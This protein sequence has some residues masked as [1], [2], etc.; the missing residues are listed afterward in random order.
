M[1]QKEFEEKVKEM[2]IDTVTPLL[3]QHGKKL[4]DVKGEIDGKIKE[5]SSQVTKPAVEVGAEAVEKDPKGGF[6]SLS[7]FA[8]HVAMAEKT[9]NRHLSKELTAWEQYCK[10]ADSTTLEEGELQYGGY[11]I[12]PEFRNELWLAVEQMNEILPRCTQIPMARTMVKIPFVNGFDESG[13]LVYGGIRW[14]W[15]DELGTKDPSRPKLGRI[16]LE[17][18]KI[19]GLAYSSDELL[20][21]SP[22]SIENVLR[23]GFTDGLNFELTNVLI[24]GTGAG[25]PLGILNAPCLVTVT[26]ETGQSAGTIVFEN[27]V[28]M[29]SR[30]H[31]PANAVWVANSNT[32]PQL[33][34]MSLSV[35]TGGVPVFMPANGAAGVPYNTLMGRP[36]IFS[37]HC[38]TLGTVGDI[39]FADWS[40]YLVGMKSGQGATGKFDTS[41]H[42][43]FDADQT[44]FRFVFRIDGQP[45][46]PSALTPPQATSDTLSPFVALASRT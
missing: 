12:P 31:N 16:T 24:R 39:V 22:I 26:K 15:T 19:A 34:T 5:I 18:R 6:K 11:L 35:G 2:L 7:H 10:A 23:N 21:D 38:A 8:Q 20:E 33:C 42:F 13:K 46:W 29:Y 30:I 14:Y 27:I 37:K 32:L 36:L 1:T 43:K 25:Q 4:E 45:W 28:K 41:I 3:E 9:G 44:A 17:L 40:Q